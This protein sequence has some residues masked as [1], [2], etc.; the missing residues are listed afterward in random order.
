MAA[1][2]K[3][4]FYFDDNGNFCGR[5]LVATVSCREKDDDGLTLLSLNIRLM[6]ESNSIK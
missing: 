5:K 1:I 2:M 6:D 3:L 4:A